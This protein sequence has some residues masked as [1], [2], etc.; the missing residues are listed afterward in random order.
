MRG[1]IP[2]GLWSD[3]VPGLVGE[4]PLGSTTAE[5]LYCFLGDGFQEGLATPATLAEGPLVEFSDH[6]DPRGRCAAVHG[7]GNCGQ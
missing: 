5:Q 3:D 6:Y 2:V 7:G 1:V 4:L